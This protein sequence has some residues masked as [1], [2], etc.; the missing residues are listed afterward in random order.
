M[1]LDLEG[2]FNVDDFLDEEADIAQSVLL[3]NERFSSEGEPGV[4]LVEGDMLDPKVFD[5]ISELRFNMNH[6]S[7]KDPERFTALPT[8]E[9]EMHAIDELVFWAMGSM[10][11]DSEPFE[12]AGWN[13]SLPGNGVECETINGIPDTQSRGC[14]QF[15]Y[16]YLSVYGIPAAGIIPEIPL[17]WLW[18]N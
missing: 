13:D 9:I 11:A 1:M 3:I 17:H 2:D 6:V 7:P 16:G 15:L 14:L 8:G 5:A 12:N 4:I 10:M 18:M